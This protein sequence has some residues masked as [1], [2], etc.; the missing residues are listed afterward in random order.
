MALFAT[1]LIAGFLTILAPCI[2]PLLPVTLGGAVAEAGNRRRPFVIIAALSVSVFAFTLLLKGSTALLDVSPTFWTY[3]SAGIL[4]LFGLTLVF[5]YA[6]AR[7]V[8][9]IPGH[10]R[11][12]SWMA[13][14]Y[15]HRGEWWADI[16]VGA[17]LGPIFTTCS[18]TFFLI[19][20]TVLPQSLGAGIID[21]LAYVAGLAIA[22]LLV[23]WIGQKLVNRL[24]WA[25]NPTGWFR[26]T[27]GVLFVLIAV[28]IAAGWDKQAES[29]ILRAGFFDVTTLE[30]QIRQVFE[31][32][33]TTADQA[34]NGSA[35]DPSE[36]GC[37]LPEGA[38]TS[39]IRQM[40]KPSG[41]AGTPDINE[42]I[43]G[44]VNGG[45]YT[46]IV[47]PAGFVNS[48]PFKL[49]D[50][51]G[52]KVILVDFIDY[53]CINCERTFPYMADWWKQYKDQGLEIV[54]IHTPEFSFE[55]DI[56]NVTAAAKQFGLEFPIVLDNSYATWN[57]YR[58]QYWPH[59]YI[60]DIH[61]RV[62][63][64][65]I[66]EGEYD[67]T[68]K[69]IVK[70]LNIRKMVLG[71]TGAVVAGTTT[72]PRVLVQAASPE[73]YFGAMRNE[74]FGNGTPGKVGDARYEAPIVLDSNRFYLDGSWHIDSEYIESAAASS[75]ISYEFAATRMYLVAESK[76]SATK[77][78]W[79]L[80]DGIPMPAAL[81]GDDVKDGILTVNS[82]RLYNIYKNSL[83]GSH[84]IDIIWKKPGARLYTFTF[85]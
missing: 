65:H 45:R 33:P 57:A 59:K 67:L 35:C 20:A 34:L 47:S 81:A 32:M 83:P 30:Q 72:M 17:A 78:A 21:L 75:T 51:I 25:T 74:Y 80:L 55:R 54:A 69:E 10:N 8:L 64:E 58:N 6:W 68:E 71:E 63:Y 7:I 19:L 28:V 52:K 66:G 16:L 70:Q 48:A 26:R 37:F 56:K 15:K 53:S 27:L 77:Q 24:E 36:K 49:A 61:G 2:L 76:D 31:R 11:P 9:K 50:L 39:T 5:P 79:I 3:V 43:P 22:L 85:G 40:P 23:A 44:E 62:V 60:I 38:A 84:R 42:K 18:P 41:Q 12:D 13:S 73:T 14:G 82:S 29:A 4:A 1:S 46:E